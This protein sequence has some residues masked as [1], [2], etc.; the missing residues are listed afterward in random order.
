M[1]YCPNLFRNRFLLTLRKVFW[2]CG[3]C[4]HQKIYRQVS[5]IDWSAVYG[6]NVLS[7][8][9]NFTMATR[10]R[11]TEWSFTEI[12]SCLVGLLEAEIH[13]ACNS[14]NSKEGQEATLFQHDQKFFFL[15]RRIK[16]YDSPHISSDLNKLISFFRM[17]KIFVRKYQ[18]LNERISESLY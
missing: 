8:R 2:L 10:F 12:S 16:I 7:S 11:P 18:L 3:S 1:P 4:D 5:Q 15:D 13:C 6:G 9:S 14:D 17:N